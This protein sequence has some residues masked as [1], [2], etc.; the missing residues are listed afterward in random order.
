MIVTKQGDKLCGYLPESSEH[1]HVSMSGHP[2]ACTM[3]YGHG[4]PTHRADWPVWEA[5][6]RDGYTYQPD[7]EPEPHIGPPRPFANLRISGLL[8]LIN[9]STFHPR[10]YALALHYDEYGDAIGW[11]ITGDGTEPSTVPDD[12]ATQRLQDATFTLAQARAD[13]SREPTS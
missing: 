10:G 2:A 8:W 5:L 4:G 13:N 3:K 6:F 11:S 12:T 1:L 9:A 7:P